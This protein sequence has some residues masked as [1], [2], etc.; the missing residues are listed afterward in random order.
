M[1]CRRNSSTSSI[2]LNTLKAGVYGEPHHLEQAQDVRDSGPM[3]PSQPRLRTLCRR[4]KQAGYTPT[5]D[6]GGVGELQQQPWNPPSAKR[7]VGLSP[8]RGK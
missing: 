2:L 8:E 1:P 3:T 4:A 7:L 6:V 5:V